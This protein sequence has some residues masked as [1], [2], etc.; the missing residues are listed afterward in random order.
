MPLYVSLN[1]P[2]ASARP[3]GAGDGDEG[4]S[5]FLFS[6]FSRETFGVFAALIDSS[7]G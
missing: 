2:K 6:V 7:E 4:N 1:E 3:R 5:F